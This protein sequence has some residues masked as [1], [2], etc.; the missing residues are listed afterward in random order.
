MLHDFTTNAS[1]LYAAIR[2]LTYSKLTCL[3]HACT[4]AR[5]NNSCTTAPC[6]RLCST[7]A[8]MQACSMPASL[9]HAYCSHAR[10]LHAC[11][12]PAVATYASRCRPAWTPSSELFLQPEVEVYIEPKAPVNANNIC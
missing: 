3:Q 7:S 2:L 12:P 1:S 8:P 4:S 5:L 9:H 11:I 6:L 10:L